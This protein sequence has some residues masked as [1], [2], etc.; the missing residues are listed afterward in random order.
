MPQPLLTCVTGPRNPER[1]ADRRKLCPDCALTGVYSRQT[2]SLTGEYRE[3]FCAG[4]LLKRLRKECLGVP[5]DA[6]NGPLSKR[7]RSTTPTSLRSR[8]NELRVVSNSVAQNPRS[9]PAVLRCD[10]YLAVYGRPEKDRRGNC[11]RPS[12]VL[13]LLTAIVRRALGP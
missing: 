6:S 4:K 11:V 5:T 9:N 13:E 3:R 8:I 12:D 7:A 1:Q 10:L 2:P